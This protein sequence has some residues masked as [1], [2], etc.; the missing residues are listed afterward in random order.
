MKYF[1]HQ[2]EFWLIVV[3]NEFDLQRNPV[4]G[5]K[6][7]HQA[8]SMNKENIKFWTQYFEFEV[9]V[10]ILFEKRQQIIQKAEKGILNQDEMEMEEDDVKESHNASVNSEVSSIQFET[11]EA[12]GKKTIKTLKEENQNPENN[13]QEFQGTDFTNHLN[14]LKIVLD[15]MSVYCD[16]NIDSCFTELSSFLKIEK[17]INPDCSELLK[18]F[19][20]LVIQKSNTRNTPDVEITS[21]GFENVEIKSQLSFLSW[22]IKNA[23]SSNEFQET[24][25]LISKINSSSFCLKNAKEIKDFLAE[26]VKVSFFEDDQ[27]VKEI[28][29]TV[30]FMS[31]I[32]LIYIEFIKNDFESLQNYF[33][34]L[35]K[36]Q[37][38]HEFIKLIP[39]NIKRTLLQIAFKHLVSL[40]IKDCSQIEEI[41]IWGLKM[42]NLNK[43]LLEILGMNLLESDSFKNTGVASQAKVFQMFLELK[44]FCPKNV[45]IEFIES[46]KE[47]KNFS[48]IERLMEFKKEEILV[49]FSLLKKLKSL[50]KLKE[51]ETYRNK[52]LRQFPEQ[53]TQIIEFYT[54]I[55]E[56]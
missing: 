18:S 43:Q 48:Q 32:G 33:Q 36:I 7:F 14:V 5:R 40:Q 24:S 51:L 13:D 19:Q 1:S 49:W 11:D 53:S 8:L 38:K 27:I 17:E 25:N 41:V 35:S 23:K 46:S 44:N 31:D 42:A 34:T 9:K 6:V 50:M 3:Y 15:K 20:M 56:N 22:K 39:N 45:A 2:L 47:M 28:F 29:E 37:L 10:F 12:A 26:I 30:K 55:I 54:K 21:E 4:K 52:C 16:Q